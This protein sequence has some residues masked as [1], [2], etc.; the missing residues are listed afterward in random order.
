MKAAAG[1]LVAVL[2]AAGVARA[3]D[4]LDC[5]IASGW[6]PTGPVRQYV[7]DNLYEYK[8]GAADGYLI[9]GFAHMRTIDQSRSEAGHRK[10]WYGRTGAGAERTL[11]QRQVLR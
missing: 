10:D 5:H 9:Y 6:E 11:R 1:L 2:F 8:D 4:A 3:Q 7:A